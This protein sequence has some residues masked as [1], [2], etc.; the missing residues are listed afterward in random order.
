MMYRSFE[1]TGSDF[2]AMMP[3]IIVDSLVRQ[4][5]EFCWMGA[6]KGSNRLEY[7]EEEIPRLLERALTD[8]REDT[9]AFGIGQ[10]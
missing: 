1:L 3:P 7:V 9:A 2:L 10:D 4:A 6:P 8:L 5:I